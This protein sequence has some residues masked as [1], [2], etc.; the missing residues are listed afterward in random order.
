VVLYDVAR[1]SD[2]Q[3][4]KQA[5]RRAESFGDL[6]A[7][8]LERYAKRYKE[9]WREDQRKLE[10]DILPYWQDRRAKGIKRK[11]VV[12]ILE[13]IVER[14]SPVAANRTLALISRIFNFGVDEE[15]VDYNPAQRVRPPHRET[16]RERVLTGSEIRRIWE[17]LEEMH[18]VMAS[19]FKLRLLTAQRGVEV[20]SMRWLDLDGEWWT[21]SG[22]VTKNGLAHRVPLSPQ[23]LAVIDRLRPLTEG[24]E[25]VFASPKKP[26]AHIVAVRKGCLRLCEETGC[27]FTPHDLRRTA[28]SHMTSMGISRL[29]VSKILNHVEQG[30]TAVYDRHSYDGEKRE[31]LLRWGG[32]VEELVRVP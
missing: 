8:Y 2:P 24:S 7:D 17:A 28:A 10:T 29:V 4:R 15:I 11:D 25:W 14:G 19:T 27:H 1:G 18:P 26:Q 20:L 3:E 23:A 9:T 13:R 30:I 32:R 16:A 12:Q 31:A 22:E 21:I 6:A 5:E